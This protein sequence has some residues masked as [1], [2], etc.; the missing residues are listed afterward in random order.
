MFACKITKLVFLDLPKLQVELS[1]CYPVAIS[2]K[3]SLL[4]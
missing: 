1:S 3:D 2:N 4:T